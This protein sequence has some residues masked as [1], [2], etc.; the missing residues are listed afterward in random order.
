MRS[1]IVYLGVPSV[2]LALLGSAAFAQQVPLTQQGPFCR[3]AYDALNRHVG[4]PD[5]N[6]VWQS[7]KPGDTLVIPKG[8]V[9]LAAEVCD[10]TQQIVAVPGTGSGTMITCVVVAPPAASQTP[11]TLRPGSH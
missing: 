4:P 8:M 10:Y 3:A 9:L 1:A 7:C 5:S 6:I 2:L 11:Q